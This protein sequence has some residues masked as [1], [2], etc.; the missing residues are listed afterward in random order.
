[1]RTGEGEVAPSRDSSARGGSV[2]AAPRGEAI[3]NLLAAVGTFCERP[4]RYLSPA[5]LGEELVQLRHI[6]DRLELEFSVSAARFAATDEYEAQG[7]VSPIDWIR[8]QC[9]MSGHAASERV[10]VGEEIERLP[11]SSEAMGEGRIGFAHLAL[12]ARTSSALHQSPTTNGL[13]EGA[14]LA[15]ASEL[16]VGRFRHVCFHARHA[17]DPQGYAADEA[18]SVADR[19]LELNTGEDGFVFIKGLL[20]SAGGAVLRTALE[21]LAVRSGADDD[22]HRDRRLADALVELCSHGL[23]SGAVP[24]RA[25]QRAH[26]Q[27]TASLETLRGISGASAGELEFSLPISARAWLSAWPATPPSPGCCWAPTPR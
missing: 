27:V 20:D 16:S 23:D 18:R 1:M 24:Q 26:L 21:P 9:K 11:L 14:L 17:A 12:M 22:R 15:S 4:S 13:D 7:S 5:Q 6:C 2:G 8:H 3:V 19:I 10:C 25:S